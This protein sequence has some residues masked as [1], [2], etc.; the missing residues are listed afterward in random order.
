MEATTTLPAF[1]HHSS[2]SLPLSKSPAQHGP[3]RLPL[4][5][6]PVSFQRFVHMLA[7]NPSIVPG[8][9]T[10]RWACP[11]AGLDT[12]TIRYDLKAIYLIREAI[13][14]TAPMLHRHCPKLLILW[15]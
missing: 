6:L 8:I 14:Q 2:L 9:R 5:F 1:F 12:V 10:W 3:T 4:L 13:Q 15:R 7:V 11:T